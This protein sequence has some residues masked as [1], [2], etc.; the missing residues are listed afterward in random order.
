MEAPL[1]AF[2]GT[3]RDWSAQQ[4]RPAARVRQATFFSGWLR[5]AFAAGALALVAGFGIDWHFR[6]VEAAARADQA[7]L[8]SV[9]AEIA[10]PVPASLAPLANLM[11]SSD[12]TNINSEGLAR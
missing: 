6:Q 1:A 2:R 4:M 8:E 5:V 10:R 11:S 9:D 12:S 3:V 7:L